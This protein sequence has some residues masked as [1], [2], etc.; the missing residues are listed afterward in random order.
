MKS[1]V[2]LSNGLLIVNQ[3]SPQFPELLVFWRPRTPPIAVSALRTLA[4]ALRRAADG[5]RVDVDG[6]MTVRVGTWGGC[7]MEGLPR[8]SGGGI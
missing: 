1:G 7:I 8:G 3:G 2:L 4:D 6:L 5:T